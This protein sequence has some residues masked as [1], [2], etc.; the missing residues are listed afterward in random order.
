[1]KRDLKYFFVLILLFLSTISSLFSQ[2]S[3]P[4]TND[5]DSLGLND[6]AYFSVQNS[7][8]IENQQLQIYFYHINALLEFQAVQLRRYRSFIFILIGAIAL[9]FTFL[10]LKRVSKRFERNVKL[11][12]VKKQEGMP[13]AI[14]KTLMQYWDLKIP[15]KT[16]EQRFETE[17]EGPPLLNDFVEAVESLGI[18]CHVIKSSLNELSQATEIPVMVL[19]NNHMAIL[20]KTKK[21]KLMLADPFYGYLE[22]EPYYFANSWFT[23]KTKEKGVFVALIANKLHDKKYRKIS[24]KLSQL[25]K[26][27]KRSWR[28]YPLY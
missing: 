26:L 11:V 21:Q 28:N 6:T 17:K 1:M 9:I 14:L 25:E 2:V 22:M 18:E 7:L 24:E 20:Y 12:M 19:F 27:D 3:V 10:M 13:A 16:L 8:Q 4:D 23:D 5:T 15:I